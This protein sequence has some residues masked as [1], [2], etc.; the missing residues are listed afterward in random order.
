MVLDLVELPG[1]A[2]AGWTMADLGLHVPLES[3]YVVERDGRGYR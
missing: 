2:R 1:R 3:S